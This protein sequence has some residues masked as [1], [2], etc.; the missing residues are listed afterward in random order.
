[1]PH[2]IAKRL[3]ASDE[4]SVRWKVRVGVLGEDP[5]S[6]PI[7]RLQSEI[8][9]SPRVR[10]LIE[11]HAAMNAGTY[12]KWLGGHWVLAALAAL[13]HP[14]GDPAL[15]PLR[16]GVLRTWLGRRYFREVEVAD[17]G[18]IPKRAAVPVIRGRARRCGSQ[19]GNALLSVVRLGL[20]D[21]R[22]G[23]SSSGS[24]TGS[25]RTA[26]GTAT[27][28]GGLLVL[29]LRDTAPDAWAC[30]VRSCTQRRHGPNTANHAAEVLL[31]RRVLFR[32]SDARLIDADWQGP[33]PRVL[34]LRPPRRLE[35]PRGGTSDP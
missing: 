19:Q 4:P 20:E 12:S 28:V 23:S 35:G 2:S 17:E 5:G 3:L 21:E 32:R 14:E 7:R 9:R 26:G 29:R 25:G 30:R 34:V 27:K 10:A 31:E 15:E 22:S 13:G 6:A 11:G 18:P 33:I 1:M 24:C 8:R 16:D